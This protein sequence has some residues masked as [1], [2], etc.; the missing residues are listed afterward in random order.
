MIC[1]LGPTLKLILRREKI[2]EIW[3]VGGGDAIWSHLL[4][5]SLFA[6]A[7]K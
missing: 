7:V 2:K 6:A 5:G 1:F 3:W 4:G